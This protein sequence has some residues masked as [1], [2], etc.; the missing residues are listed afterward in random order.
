MPAKKSAQNAE[1]LLVELGTEELPPKSLA[2]LGRSFARNLHKHLESTGLLEEGREPGYEWYATPRRLGLRIFRVRRKQPGQ[3]VERRG[4]SIAAAFDSS[5]KPTPAALGFA[6]SC[7]T[8]VE[9][10]GRLETEKGAWLVYSYKQKGESLDQLIG[11]GLEFA[12]KQLPIRKRMRWGE[13]DAEFV[14]PVHW[15]VVLH[16]SRAVKTSLLA[17]NAGTRS[18]GHRFHADKNIPITHADKY[19][20]T[21]RIRGRVIADFA[22][23]RNMIAGQVEKLTKSVKGRMHLDESLLDEV[24]GLVEW[25][26]GVLGTFD[27]E[28]LDIPQ[29]CLVSSMRDHQKYF[30]IT[31][32]NGRLLPSFITI[33]NIRSKS[34]ARVRNGNQRVLRARLSDARFFW[35]TDLKTSLASRCP[36]LE[37]VLFHVELG[38]VLDKTRRME[39]L[40]IAI[41]DK[42]GANVKIA[43]RAALLS[44][45]DLVS[46]M[47]GEFPELQGIM[48]RYYADHDKEDEELSAAIEQHYWPR[49]SGDKIADSGIGQAVSLADRIDTLAGIFSTGE[50]P[51]GEKDP[52]ALRRAALG[53]L[54]TIIERKLD[55]DLGELLRSSAASYNDK[56]KI[57]VSSESSDRLLDF[58]LDRL[59]SWYSAAG[60][61]TD[62]I[63]SVL[64]CRPLRPLDFDLRL[65]AV[66]AF[67]RL[68]EAADLAAA[69]KRIGNIL[70]RAEIIPSGEVRQELM[71]EGAEKS[72][73][74]ELDSLG[75]DAN[76]LFRENQFEAGLKIL[77]GLR[78]P[79]DKF[80]DEVMVMAED[81]AA[82]KNRLAMLKKLQELF[83]RVA[84]IS[85]LQ[86]H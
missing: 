15:L 34:P 60:F 48:G 50:E 29:E 71:T 21:L 12:V 7:G 83:L 32:R 75:D 65:R 74:R 5:G 35:E 63:R 45:A 38:S 42:I 23:R 37:S 61:Q 81:K 49:Y 22:E 19:T 51:T 18:R 59:R 6:G 40:A 46:G 20:Q 1:T 28:F 36:E 67:R 31:N 84:D 52:Y 17:V 16:G 10:L 73:L 24:T 26:Y 57:K 54:R 69:N 70:R 56:N 72:L 85:E 44:K 27:K 55:L 9:K 66:T 78:D 14:R 39:Q 64:A 77:A 62:E 4:P 8:S 30:H 76:K 11:E 82:Q 80:F 3:L 41:A 68:P 86:R 25:P 43:G 58:M 33:S 47:V 13:G 2:A 79:V 53:V